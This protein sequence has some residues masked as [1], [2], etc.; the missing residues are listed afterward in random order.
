MAL[1]APTATGPFAVSVNWRHTPGSG[2]VRKL[3][4]W[5]SQIWR[6]EGG[7]WLVATLVVDRAHLL[8]PLPSR[9]HVS[10]SS[11]SVCKGGG[12]QR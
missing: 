12:G 7:Q 4:P 1:R 2:E 8:A 9:E 5:V 11:G 3:A 6:E 10:S